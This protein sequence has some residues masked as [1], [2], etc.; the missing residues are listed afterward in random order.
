LLELTTHEEGELLEGI[1]L[2]G[3]ALAEVLQDS[4]AISAR[5]PGPEA[6]RS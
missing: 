4:N 1:R 2:L 3:K 5:T 6:V